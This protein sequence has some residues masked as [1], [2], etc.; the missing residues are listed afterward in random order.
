MGRRKEEEDGHTHTHTQTGRQAFTP[1]IIKIFAHR[2]AMPGK[3]D[4]DD[5]VKIV[6]NFVFHPRLAHVLWEHYSSHLL[7][8][9]IKKRMSEGGR[10]KE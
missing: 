3:D 7:N 5:D 4:D 2:N 8:M 10:E 6:I 9:K 1:L